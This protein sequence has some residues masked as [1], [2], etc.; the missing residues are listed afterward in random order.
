M[1]MIIPPKL[2]GRI[3]WIWRGRIE[4]LHR[5]RMKSWFYVSFR[6]FWI[7]D[8]KGSLNITRDSIDVNVYKYCVMK[9]IKDYFFDVIFISLLNENNI[10]VYSIFERILIDNNFSMFV[11]H[12]HVISYYHFSN[13]KFV[14]EW[15][16]VFS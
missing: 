9:R 5:D 1:H 11:S 15:W 6:Y 13:P 12:V 3:S 16:M 8:K 2:I 7:K 14:N 10:K 4:W